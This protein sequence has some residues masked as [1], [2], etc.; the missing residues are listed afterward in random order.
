MG[1]LYDWKVDGSGPVFAGFAD[2][3]ARV[4]FKPEKP[5]VTPKVFHQPE[6]TP[7]QIAMQAHVRNLLNRIE[8]AWR[9][10][11]ARLPEAPEG[12]FWHPVMSYEDTPI[13][14]Q[15]TMLTNITIRP[16]L[17]RE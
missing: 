16:E 11:E 13:W 14:E 10:M 17:H 12:Y 6:P 3:Q 8:A 4:V 7:Y 2:D 9:E 5:G 15:N 1:N